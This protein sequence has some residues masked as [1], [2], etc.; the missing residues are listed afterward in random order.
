[1][2]KEECVV[3]GFGE[4]RGEPRSW[5]KAMPAEMWPF[6]WELQIITKDM[7]TS[8]FMKKW[9]RDYS[10]HLDYCRPNRHSGE[11]KRTLDMEAF[12]KY[13]DIFGLS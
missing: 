12:E 8:G 2:S 13:G 5:W 3:L 4:G 10:L 6:S 11:R 7:E 1:M 9:Q